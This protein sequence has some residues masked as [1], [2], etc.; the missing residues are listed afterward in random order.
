MVDKSRD[1][2]EEGGGGGWLLQKVKKL[3]GPIALGPEW[4]LTSTI[5]QAL[6]KLSLT[7]HAGSVGAR[8]PV[9][10]G[11]IRATR[12]ALWVSPSSPR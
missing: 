9:G 6:R 7:R 11:A 3:A 10:I 2:V 12:G 8:R 5:G 1:E 4:S